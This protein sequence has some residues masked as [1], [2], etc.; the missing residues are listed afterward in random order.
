MAKPIWRN[1][2]RLFLLAGLSPVW[3]LRLAC[4]RRNLRS[5]T[6]SVEAT[7]TGVLIAALQDVSEHRKLEQH[8]ASRLGF[9]RSLIP[10]S[11]TGVELPPEILSTAEGSGRYLQLR[12]QE[13]EEV[14]LATQKAPPS[15]S[16]LE[17]LEQ[18]GRRFPNYHAATVT[19]GRM[20]NDA[21]RWG[22]AVD[23]L[24]R[25]VILEPASAATLC[26][27]GR[28]FYFR[29]EFGSVRKCFEEA[30]RINPWYYPG[31][32]YFLR[33]LRFVRATDATD[34]AVRACKVFPDD[35]PLALMAIAVYPPQ[36]QI[37]LLSELLER[38]WPGQ[39]RK[40]AVRYWRSSNQSQ[41]RSTQPNTIPLG[42]RSF[43]TPL[44]F[45]RILPV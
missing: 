33:F 13:A 32:L 7:R 39:I 11:P 18:L 10:T 38:V 16:A 2:R 17:Q 31:W 37:G 24:H 22:E 25:A 5:V 35:F 6:F 42:P 15:P 34:W 30:F 36:Q 41:G 3:S 9:Y 28:S 12:P 8:I 21:K 45:F 14:F 29:D 26:E 4:E 43:A 40:T 23:V 19:R 1:E 44:R 27:L 20:L